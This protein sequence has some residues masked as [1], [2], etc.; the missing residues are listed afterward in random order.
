MSVSSERGMVLALPRAA[1]CVLVAGC[2][3]AV[4]CPAACPLLTAADAPATDAQLSNTTI[5]RLTGRG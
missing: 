3:L 5:K 2:R 4:W 1:R